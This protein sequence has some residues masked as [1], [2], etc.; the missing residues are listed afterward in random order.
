MNSWV[1]CGLRVTLGDT[2]TH[3][4]TMVKTPFPSFYLLFSLR[5]VKGRL[6]VRALGA[7]VGYSA[8]LL[9]LSTDSLFLET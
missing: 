5:I 7:L 9:A 4:T 6:R 1:P 8:V 3:M 2:L